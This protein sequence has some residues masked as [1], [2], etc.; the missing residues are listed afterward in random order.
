MSSDA[1]TAII[2]QCICAKALA[3]PWTMGVTEYGFVFMHAEQHST[4]HANLL[5]ITA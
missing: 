2:H 4:R 1:S 5:R 3:A